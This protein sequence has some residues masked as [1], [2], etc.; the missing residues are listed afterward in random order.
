MMQ[1]RT[2]YMAAAEG[3]RG[4]TVKCPPAPIPKTHEVD[5]SCKLHLRNFIRSL[6]CFLKKSILMEG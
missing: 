4:A 3:W 1:L 5:V 2:L 6:N